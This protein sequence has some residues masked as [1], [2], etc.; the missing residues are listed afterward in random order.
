MLVRPSRAGFEPGGEP[1]FPW[2]LPNTPPEPE[3]IIGRWRTLGAAEKRR[4][5]LNRQFSIS[6]ATRV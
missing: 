2:P 1:I 5:L 3:S 4:D 6:T